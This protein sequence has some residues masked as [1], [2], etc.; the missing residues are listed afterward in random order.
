MGG[1]EDLL[2]IVRETSA[3]MSADEVMNYWCG[4]MHAG[5]RSSALRHYGGVGGGEKEDGS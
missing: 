4:W 5:T 3:W 2:R 1:V